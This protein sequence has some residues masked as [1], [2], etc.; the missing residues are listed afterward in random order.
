MDLKAKEG[1]ELVELVEIKWADSINKA[2]VV[3]AHRML[4]L[5]Y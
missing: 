2:R 5:F 4:S 3:P 1:I